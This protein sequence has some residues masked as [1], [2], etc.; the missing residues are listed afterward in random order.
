M[1]WE[2]NSLI[3]RFCAVQNRNGSLN[4]ETFKGIKLKKNLKTLSDL[5]S[6]Y[7]R[8]ILQDFLSES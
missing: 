1:K 8:K 4:H 6:F 5:Q 7:L 2:N 3:L